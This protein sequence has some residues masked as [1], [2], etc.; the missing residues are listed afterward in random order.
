MGRIGETGNPRTLTEMYIHFLVVPLK[1]K[2]FKYDGGAETDSHW[3]LQSR[4]MIE[5]L[6]KLAFEQLQKGNLIF[7]E[8]DLA[9]CGISIRAASVY[10]GVFT[11]IFKEERDLCQDQMFCFVHVS[12]SFLLLFTSMQHSSTLVLICCQKNKHQPFGLQYFKVNTI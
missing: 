1:L 7:Y 5:S 2:N 12:K 3:H 10:S 4:N 8:S 11:K 9:E 6:G